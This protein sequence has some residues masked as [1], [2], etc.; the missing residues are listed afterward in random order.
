VGERTE[1]P[2][3]YMGRG[4]VVDPS[5]ALH[6]Y[7]RTGGSPRIGLSHPK[8][9]EYLDKEQQEFDPKTG[10]D[11]EQVR[12]IDGTNI[13]YDVKGQWPSSAAGARRWS[14]QS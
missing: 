9:D 13:S 4:S 2:F 1:V 7:F 12:S 10:Q 3:Y 8:I 5:R 6:Q 11:M 14:W